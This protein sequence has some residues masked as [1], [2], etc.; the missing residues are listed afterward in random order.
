[1]TKLRQ[2]IK[3][4]YSR[5]D[6]YVLE[7]IITVAQSSSLDNLDL[8]SINA[9]WAFSKISS[10]GDDAKLDAIKILIDWYNNYSKYEDDKESMYNKAVE[11]KEEVLK[12]INSQHWEYIDRGET[13]ER[14]LFQCDLDL[15]EVLD[16]F[17]SQMKIKTYGTMRGG[18]WTSINY[19]T[20]TGVELQIGKDR[21]DAF[22]YKV[23]IYGLKN[24]AS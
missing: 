24:S 7:D 23:V 6:H 12:V 21:S 18:S 15:D 2:F 4:A 3:E 14:I 20:D 9:K 11:V 17:E 8:K 16:I 22:N 19:K 10:T 13:E 1:M 5:K